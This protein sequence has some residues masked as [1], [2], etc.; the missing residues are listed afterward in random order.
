MRSFRAF[1]NASAGRRWVHRVREPRDRP[2]YR[3]QVS[4]PG[5]EARTDGIEGECALRASRLRRAEPL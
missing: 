4:E 5:T 3:S 2:I 1:A